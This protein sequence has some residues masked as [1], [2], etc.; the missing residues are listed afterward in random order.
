MK[1]LVEYINEARQYKLKDFFVYDKSHSFDPDFYGEICSLKFCNDPSY[2]IEM[3]DIFDASKIKKGDNENK[4]IDEWLIDT[5]SNIKIPAEPGVEYSNKWLD[6]QITKEIEKYV[7]DKSKDLL[8]KR[9]N[10]VIVRF[11]INLVV[12]GIYDISLKDEYAFDIV[13]GKSKKLEVEICGRR[14]AFKRKWTLK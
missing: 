5:I 11:G 12:S 10:N 7:L 13:K 14:F 8:T 3:K 9:E 4:I 2:H 6:E 1:S